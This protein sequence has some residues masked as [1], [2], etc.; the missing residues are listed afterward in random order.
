VLQTLEIDAR[1][2][3]TGKQASVQVP[4]VADYHGIT[5]E[6]SFVGSSSLEDLRDVREKHSALFAELE[7]RVF[8][9][10]IGAKS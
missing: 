4:R 7:G 2:I 10:R 9:V 5:A 6:I 8:L 1:E 3:Q